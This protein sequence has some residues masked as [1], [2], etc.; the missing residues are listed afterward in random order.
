LNVILIDGQCVFCN[1]LVGFI[2]DHDRRGDFCFAHVQSDFA[3]GILERHGITADVDAIY[4]V[5][6]ADTPDER[7]AVDG[8]AGR[9]I[10]PRLFRIAIVLRW[11]PLP[12]LDL[13]YR[14]FARIRYR[15]FGKYDV[16]RVPV[17]EER[18]RFVG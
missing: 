7:V 2:L 6:G 11:I 8:R 3:R 16:C 14:M 1:R 18:S 5:I 15:L 4:L 9:E 12:L 17:G 10:W 13:G